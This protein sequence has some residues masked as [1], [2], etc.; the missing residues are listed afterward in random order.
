[1]PN[2]APALPPVLQPASRQGREH[3]PFTIDEMAH[4]L[5]G[6]PRGA[7]FW[8]D[9][10]AGLC[11]VVGIAPT[12]VRDGVTGPEASTVGAYGLVLQLAGAAETAD[13]QPHCSI[14]EDRY[15]RV[16]QAIARGRPGM[17]RPLRSEEARDLARRALIE[18]SDDWTKQALAALKPYA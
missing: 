1:M 14:A 10:A 2:I 5:R 15:R 9:T 6:M 4:A 16:L 13:R 3:E 12:R 11:P 8:A 7:A 18:M 17:G